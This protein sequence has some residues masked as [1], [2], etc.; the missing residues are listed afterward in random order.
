MRK[1]KEKRKKRKKRGREKLKLE[2]KLETILL[3]LNYLNEVSIFFTYST[4]IT[5]KNPTFCSCILNSPTILFSPASTIVASIFPPHLCSSVMTECAVFAS[6]PVVGSSRKS[7]EGEVMSSMPM[8]VRFL[9]PPDTP[10]RNSV[11][12]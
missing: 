5:M 8:F 9:S 6:R 3:F 7:T 10:R 12:I 1:R 11:P 4:C 2:T